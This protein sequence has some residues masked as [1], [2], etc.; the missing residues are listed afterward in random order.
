MSTARRTPLRRERQAAVKQ[1]MCAPSLA[2]IIG[3]FVVSGPLHV[4]K[5]SAHLQP[6]AIDKPVMFAGSHRRQWV[7]RPQL[8]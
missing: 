1:W 5:Q 4:C 3:D 7:I 6:S 8:R 2:T